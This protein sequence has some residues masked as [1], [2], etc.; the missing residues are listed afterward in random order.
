MTTYASLLTAVLLAVNAV[1][2][3]TTTCKKYEA[4][5]LITG[6]FYDINGNDVGY[7]PYAFNERMEVAYYKSSINPHKN[8]TVEFQLCQPNYAQW[9]KPADYVYGRFYVPSINK[10]LA[11]T[12]PSGAPPYYVAAKPCIPEKD[13]STKASIPFNFF[14]PVSE[15]WNNYFWTGGSIPSKNVWQGPEPLASE[16]K[17]R[18]AVNATDVKDGWN[19]Q[20]GWGE[21]NPSASSTELNRVHVYCSTK[22]GYGIT[23]D[24]VFRMDDGSHLFGR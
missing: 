11:V 1:Q 6:P 14:A 10:C 12:N 9:T 3:A 17:G 18:F 8:I 20:G 13:M 15:Q 24:N 2:A 7:K 5:T 22:N 19:N 16:C 21:P 23:A 4:G